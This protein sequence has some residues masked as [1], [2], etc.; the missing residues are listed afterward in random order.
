MLY[1]LQ[2]SDAV[3]ENTNPDRPLSAR[4]RGDVEAV[5]EFTPGI[6]ARRARGKAAANWAL[7]WMI[8]PI[9]PAPRILL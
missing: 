4:R 8:R 6:L 7:Q 3:S 5:A 9:F 1:L 2:N